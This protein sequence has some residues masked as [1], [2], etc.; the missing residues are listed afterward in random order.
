MIEYEKK[1]NFDSEYQ[2]ETAAFVLVVLSKRLKN[3]L[4]NKLTLQQTKNTHRTHTNDL[5][6]YLFDVIFAQYKYTEQFN[7]KYSTLVIIRQRQAQRNVQ[8]S[9][10]SCTLYWFL[11]PGVSVICKSLN[12]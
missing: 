7:L 10:N 8:S 1:L 12:E 9:L 2:I 4:Y 11:F 3:I 6:W 5:C